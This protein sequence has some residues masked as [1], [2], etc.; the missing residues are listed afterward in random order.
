MTD[1]VNVRLPFLFKSLTDSTDV[2]NDCI[3][4][5]NSGVEY[6][7]VRIILAK[8][9]KYFDNYFEVNDQQKLPII[10]NVDKCIDQKAMIEFLKFLYSNYLK[11]DVYNIPALLKIARHY[12]FLVIGKLLERFYMD[13]AQNDD[14]LIHFVSEF[15]KY[16]LESDALLLAP[17]IALHLF[18]IEKKDPDEKFTCTQI[19]QAVTPRVFAEIL[20]EKN[21]LEDSKISRD[22]LRSQLYLYDPSK[23]DIDKKNILHIENYVKLYT[24]HHELTEN[25]KE[26]LASVIEWDMEKNSN[27]PSYLIK[28]KCDWLP[29]NYSQPLIERILK[30]RNLRIKQFNRNLKQQPD[31]VSRWFSLSWIR[32]IKINEAPNEDLPIIEFIRTIGG[33]SKPVD[34]VKHGLIKVYSSKPLITKNKPQNALIRDP[35]LY[36]ESRAFDKQPPYISIDLGPNTLFRPRNVFFDSRYLRE[37]TK[38]NN[39]GIVTSVLAQVKE[40][41]KMSQPVTLSVVNNNSPYLCSF[42]NKPG[43]EIKFTLNGLTSKN[44]D[45]FRVTELEVIGNFQVDD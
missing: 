9:S 40:Q 23:V 12:E 10:I 35:K 41:D 27:A 11:L 18:R 44:F 38:Y 28:Y 6:P 24:E 36:F 7:F 3:I 19:Y 14:T 4:K 5:F 26:Y 13:A 32:T 42:N 22:P 20:K 31:Q 1:Y 16:D 39:K 29:A 33:T 25:D 8:N 34:P 37:S 17:N 43:S 21:K 30:T 45:V 15:I 2:F